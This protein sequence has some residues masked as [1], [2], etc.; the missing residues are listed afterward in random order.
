MIRDCLLAL[1]EEGWHCVLKSA[2][3][4]A[5]V[6]LATEESRSFHTTVEMHRQLAERLLLHKTH[7]G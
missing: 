6:H 4:L 1:K 2:T 7:V 3:D 5:Y